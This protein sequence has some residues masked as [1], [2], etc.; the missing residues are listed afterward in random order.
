MFYTIYKITNKIDGK[1]YIGC[2]KTSD[3]DD[4][5]M[6]SGTYLKNAQNKYGI[7]N[8]EKEILEIF[9]NPEAMFEMESILVTPE[10]VDRE[11]TYNLRLGGSGG[12]DYLNS[13]CQEQRFQASSKG[14]KNAVAKIN[15][16]IRER[17]KDPEYDKNLRNTYSKAH[18]GRKH[19]EETKQKIGDANSK[20]QQGEGNSQY[21]M[22]WI[23]SLKEKQSK[24]I[25]PEELPRWESPGWLK[26][27]KM[28]F[29]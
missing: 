26:G 17:R 20:H 21:G 19:S 8:F 5:Y 28:K 24:R 13:L 14:G 10:F 6:G 29:L 22:I 16:I 23:Y 25:L 1:I 27:R 11:D 7:E 4:G 2:H 18:T 12:F 15:A 3:L 9:D